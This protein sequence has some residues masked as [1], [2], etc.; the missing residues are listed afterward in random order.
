MGLVDLMN[1]KLCGDY[2]ERIHEILRKCM[3][4]IVNYLFKVFMKS[5]SSASNLKK[6]STILFQINV[7]ELKRYKDEVLYSMLYLYKK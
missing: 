6:K 7:S 2:F 3:M 4:N 1:T 5:V